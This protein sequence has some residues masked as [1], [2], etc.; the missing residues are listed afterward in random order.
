[1]KIKK[2][3][4]IVCSMLCILMVA[5]CGS[6]E[7]TVY[8]GDDISDSE[9]NLMAE[10]YLTYLQS[11]TQSGNYEEMKD[12]DFIAVSDMSAIGEVNDLSILKVAA[13]SYADSLNE[14]GAFKGISD[15]K[16][17]RDEE[18]LTVEVVADYEKHQLKMQLVFD[19][20][21]VLNSITADLVLTVKE[22]LMKALVN[23]LL[24]MGTVFCVLIFISMLISCFKFISK[25]QNKSKDSK[26]EAKADNKTQTSPVLETE[27]DEIDDYE[28]IAVIS[29]AI[30]VAE[31]TS[32][33]GFRVRSIK[34]AKNSTWNRA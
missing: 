31:G 23:T 29:A 19:E 26:L 1:M 7:K 10:D 3:L 24:G 21:M 14:L 18:S 8:P 2:V 17:T 12:G 11:F 28:L 16:I 32:V 15:R 33:D 34:R 13:D 25:A 4:L 27:A 30:A 5:A 9:I 20:D 6:D 22:I